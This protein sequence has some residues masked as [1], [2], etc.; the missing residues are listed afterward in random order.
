MDA[1]KKTSSDLGN[2]LEVLR[3]QL[4][5]LKREVRADRAGKKEFEDQLDLLKRQRELINKRYLNNKKWAAEFGR[6]SH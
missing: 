4:Q 5:E 1:F 6:S 2:T 3:N